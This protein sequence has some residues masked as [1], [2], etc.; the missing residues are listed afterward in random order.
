MRS[1]EER[2][3]QLLHLLVGTTNDHAIVV[4]DVNGEVVTWNPGAQRFT[5]YEAHEI[6]GRHFSC[7]Y[8]PEDIASGQPEQHLAIAAADGHYEDE[9]WRIRKDGGHY[10]A[11]VV[12][13]TLRGDDG[14][15]VGF[16]NVSRDI[17][18]RKRGEE[19]L[20][21]SEERFRLLVSAVADYAIFLLEP[22]GTVASWNLGAEHLK[23]YRAD[24]ILGHHI[25]QF[26]TEE[27]LRAGVPATALREAFEEGRWE[28]EGWRVR[29]DGSRFWANVLLTS[30]R[31]ADGSHRGYAKVTRDL[32]ERKR[33]DDA[34]RGVL[35]RE[36]EAAARLRELDQMRSELVAVIAH[37]LRAPV[38]V[39]EHLAHR[40]GVEWDTLSDDDKRDAFNRIGARAAT[41][42]SLVDDVFDMVLIDAGR[43]EIAAI[44]FD[45]GA[46]V[47]DA[48]ADIA[49]ST[50]PRPITMA[51]EPDARALGDPRRTW[52]VLSNLLSNAVKFSEPGT[53]IVVSVERRDGEVLVAVADAGIGIAADQQHLLF[54]RFTRL[55]A[56]SGSPGS[57]VGL[58]IAKSLV[59]V[60]HGRISVESTPGIGTTF[61]FRLPSAP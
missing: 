25:S 53:P 28:S 46:V 48:V 6:I 27:D 32:T 31:G 36:R 49:A 5:G 12:I 47:A 45:V 39:I 3:E 14:R 44:P 19:T 41:L 40:L 59:E 33:N 26:Y 61:R 1:D 18:E 24:E 60:Q 9:G 7:F 20:R 13:T 34:L 52:Q 43:L 58:F 23:G 51:V 4:L 50:N 42:A 21:Q 11:S 54:Q 17:T 56:S 8:R 2:G 38:G 35:A 55:S 29:K 10:W 57:G 16:G 37:D 15:L 30:L 22:N